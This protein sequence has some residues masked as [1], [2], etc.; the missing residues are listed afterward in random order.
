MNFKK[1]NLNRILTTGSKNSKD[2]KDLAK[3]KRK[4]TK[5]GIVVSKILTSKANARQDLKDKLKAAQEYNSKSSNYKGLGPGQKPLNKTQT[6][7]AKKIAMKTWHYKDT[8][9]K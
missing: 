8:N 3:A 4:Q 5:G 7:K 9:Q 2:L 6:G 1:K